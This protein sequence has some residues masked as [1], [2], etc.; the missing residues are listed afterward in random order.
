MPDYNTELSKLGSITSINIIIETI[1]FYAKWGD[2]DKVKNEFIQN[3]AFGIN[4]SSTRKNYYEA[5]KRLFLKDLDSKDRMFFINTL[6]SDYPDNKYKK[7]VLYLEI[8]RQND[9]LK[10][11]TLDLIWK[12]Y[13]ENRR[14]ITSKEVYDFL[15]ELKKDDEDMNLSES[16]LKRLSSRYISFM[17]KLSFFEPENR[18]K[19]MIAYPYPS[20][21]LITYIVYLSKAA[22]K[23]DHEI[24]E[25]ALYLAL[26]LEEE[27]RIELLKQGSLAG[28]YKF[29][30]AGKRNV[31]FELNYE[32]EEIIDAIF[33]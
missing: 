30:F 24:Y 32:R 26:M 1:S 2:L 5:I 4:M 14:L 12:K 16:T 20:K 10:K 11:L 29:N 28:Y 19:S 21:E 23:D 31:S 9:L 22:G 33:R 17:K 27:E 13:H 7:T 18:F 15:I 8:F 3:N 25:S 6:A